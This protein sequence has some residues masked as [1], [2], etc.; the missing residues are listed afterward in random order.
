M[1]EKRHQA[2][3]KERRSFSTSPTHRRASTSTVDIFIDLIDLC[4]VFIP[5]KLPSPDLVSRADNS[6][7]AI[8]SES[9]T[10][11]MLEVFPTMLPLGETL[12]FDLLRNRDAPESPYASIGFDMALLKPWL[13]LCLFFNE[14]FP[15]LN[16]EALLSATFPL[17]LLIV[18]VCCLFVLLRCF[19]VFHLRPVTHRGCKLSVFVSPSTLETSF[20]SLRNENNENNVALGVSN[21]FALTESGSWHDCA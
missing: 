8:P 16:S 3:P 10:L 18:S 6:Q 19:S 15:E 21:K 5:V 2:E 4:L 13:P 7:E 20:E 17:P 1:K 11:A 9:L 12:S 14:S